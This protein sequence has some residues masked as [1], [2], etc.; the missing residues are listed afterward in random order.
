MQ[1]ASDLGLT[2]ALLEDGSARE[3]RTA[4]LSLPPFSPPSSTI[5]MGTTTLVAFFLIF[6]VAAA[7][8]TV[9]V[10]ENLLEKRG[11]SLSPIRATGSASE[12][13][14]SACESRN[15]LV[16]KICFSTEAATP[17]SG[18]LSSPVG[19]RSFGA[20]RQPPP[21]RLHSSR[22]QSYPRARLQRHLRVILSLSRLFRARK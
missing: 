2:P 5:A 9:N 8:P 12:A 4:S 6:A 22:R 16:S 7:A 17:S 19:P 10:E 18:P 11:E 21:P 13:D 15:H 14:C 1:P 3:R 20:E